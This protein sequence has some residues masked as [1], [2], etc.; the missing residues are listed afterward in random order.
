MEKVDWDQH[1][2][3]GPIV[4]DG[5]KGVDSFSTG[6][7]DPCLSLQTDPAGV[8]TEWSANAIG[9][10][11]KTVREF[12]EK[13]MTKEVVETERGTIKLVGFTFGS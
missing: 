11:S 4:N 12:L 7:N 6:N 10:N 13:N 8:Y 5:E 9:R 1:W 2:L 3:F